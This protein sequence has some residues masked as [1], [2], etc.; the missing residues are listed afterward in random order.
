MPQGMKTD[1]ESLFFLRETIYG[2]AQIAKQLQM[3]MKQLQKIP[4]Y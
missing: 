1:K 4:I 3:K 2:L